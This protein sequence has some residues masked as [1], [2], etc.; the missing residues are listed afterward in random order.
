VTKQTVEKPL[1]ASTGKVLSTRTVNPSG[2]TN[3]VSEQ[4]KFASSGLNLYQ[5][6][7]NTLK[8]T[9][10]LEQ[11]SLQQPERSKSAITNK[12][13]EFG[14]FTGNDF[15]QTGTEHWKTTYNASIKD[16][17]AYTKSSRPEWTL[18]REPH[19]VS[20]G[21]IQSEYKSHFGE[22]G[23]NPFE[24]LSQDAIVPPKSQEI[25]KLGT[26]QSTFH[27]PGYT[28]HIPKTLTSPEYWDQSHGVNTRTTFLKQNITENYHTRIPGYSGHHPMNARNDRG[29]VR[30]FCF[31]T[32]GE[33]FH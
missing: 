26:T 9:G 14:N 18:H 15:V 3:N 7:L 20:N 2:N 25:L 30:Q 22:R 5:K 12:T 13:N 16:P 11:T 17:Y 10:N 1:L 24:K 6:T 29:N 19:T 28:G 33:T 21:P 23:D 8:K 31:S 32:D 27:I 4:D